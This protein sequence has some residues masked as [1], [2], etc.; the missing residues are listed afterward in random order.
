MA[1]THRRKDL[2]AAMLI[3]G[4]ALVYWMS[5]RSPEI[6]FDDSD[7]PNEPRVRAVDPRATTL[8]GLNRT[9]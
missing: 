6:T 9:E 2:V 4:A 7:T 5:R 3:I 8:P 1:R